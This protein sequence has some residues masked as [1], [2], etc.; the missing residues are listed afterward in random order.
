MVHGEISAFSAP[1][2]SRS[3]FLGAALQPAGGTTGCCTGYH[4]ASKGQALHGSQGVRPTPG[5][6]RDKASERS[7]YKLG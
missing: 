6:V 2:L 3:R 4:S 5:L 1:G 7:Q